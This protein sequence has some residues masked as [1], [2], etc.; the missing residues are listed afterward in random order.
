ML[1][2]I[3]ASGRPISRT[4]V[5]EIETLIGHPLPAQYVDFLLRYNGGRP[6]P[7]NFRINGFY[8]RPGIGNIQ[9]FF[10]VDSRVRSS[11][12]MWNF[13]EMNLS[14]R[15]PANLIPIACDGSGDL[16]CLAL[17]GPDTGQVVFWDYLDERDE[18]T[19]ENVYRVADSFSEFIASIHSAFNEK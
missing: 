19:Y 9:V 2:D 11:D 13:K 16:I 6:K 15:V 18:P 7:N 5:S 1:I 10:R 17:F 8:E 3:S 14:G 4:E 12:L